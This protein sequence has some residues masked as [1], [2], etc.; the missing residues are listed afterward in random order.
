MTRKRQPI[1]CDFCAKEIESQMR[2][3]A[4]FNQTNTEKPSEKGSFITSSSKADMC[5][6]CL[7]EIAKNGYKPK[8]VK[9]VKD[10]NTGKWSDQA[11]E[12]QTEL[13]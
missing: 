7:I 3:T 10:E 8:W 11:I 6:A 1:T 12:E 9:K 2:Y 13:A 4:Q 5:H